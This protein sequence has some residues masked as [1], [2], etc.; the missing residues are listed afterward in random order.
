MRI[1]NGNDHD[2]ASNLDA[3]ERGKRIGK[4]GPSRGGTGTVKLSE[5]LRKKFD[6]TSDTSG[7]ADQ[8]NFMDVRLVDLG[9]LKSITEEILGEL[10]ETETN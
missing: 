3:E 10:F 6:D 2:T 5:I 8:D 7:A 1:F 9:L 4:E